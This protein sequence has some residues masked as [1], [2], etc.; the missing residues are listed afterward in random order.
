MF[1]RNPPV[2]TPQKTQTLGYVKAL[3]PIAVAVIAAFQ[4]HGAP[5]SA[6]FGF[7]VMTFGVTL[8]EPA[9]R[10]FLRRKRWRHDDAVAR[11]A[12]WGNER[13]PGARRLK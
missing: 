6:L 13:T 11:R 9:H 10:T 3:G 7:S 5:F 8:Y 1:Q 4:Q 2:A 12:T